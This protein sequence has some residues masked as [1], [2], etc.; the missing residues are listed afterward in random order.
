MTIRSTTFRAALLGVSLLGLAGA[1]TARAAVLYT[2]LLQRGTGHI[3]CALTNLGGKAIEV[4]SIL[5]RD[6]AG[7]AISA[8][9]NLTLDPG[10]SFVHTTTIPDDGRCEFTF[11]GSKAK[12]RGVLCTAASASAACTAASE[13]H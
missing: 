3:R 8:A 9:S 1:G 10:E 4:E 13:A 2:G 6:K 5:V 7:G 11:Q 12:V